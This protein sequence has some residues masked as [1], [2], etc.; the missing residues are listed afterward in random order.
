MCKNEVEKILNINSSFCSLR[1][2]VERVILTMWAL[3]SLS[4]WGTELKKLSYL[5]WRNSQRRYL[6]WMLE[7]YWALL[8]ERYIQVQVN[9]CRVEDCFQLGTPQLLEEAIQ[10]GK[11]I[12][13]KYSLELPLL[14]LV[15]NKC[16][17]QLDD[18]QLKSCMEGDHLCPHN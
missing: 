3:V 5:R 4:V 11:N 8:T 7:R 10:L 12:S 2:A 13:L 9:S 17:S 1:Q 15:P 14:T 6:S 18:L 16:F